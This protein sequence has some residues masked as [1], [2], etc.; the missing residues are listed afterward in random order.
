MTAPEPPKVAAGATRTTGRPAVLLVDDIPANLVALEAFLGRLDCEI[1]RAP[2][3]NE[4]LKQLLRREYAVV[5]LDVQMP[6][7]DGYE[8]A[9][10]IRQHPSTREIPII[11]VTAMSEARANLLRGYESGAVDFLFKPIDPVVLVSKVEVFLSLFRARQRLQDEIDAHRRTLAE[12]EAFNYSV[13]HDLRSPVRHVEAYSSILLE[14]HGAQ[15]DGEA[16][17]HLEKIHASAKKMA[18]H[19]E[20]L[21]SLSRARRSALQRT[22]FDLATMAAGIVGELRQ[23]EPRREVELV[24]P[25]ALPVTASEGLVRIALENL[26]R[27]AWKFTRERPSARIEVGVARTGDEPAYF[28]RD[29]G[30]GFDAAR[31]TKLFQPF[32]RFHDESRFEGSGLGLVIVKTIVERHGGELRVESAPEEGA[33]FTFTLPAAGEV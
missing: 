29:D 7:M 20:G 15:L 1:Y 2:S 19:M 17:A 9:G 23:A 3:G 21:V 25:Q 27:N 16:R 5:L 12:L 6:D 10:Y 4:A 8:V 22:T 24:L 33:T 13:S 18:S 14:D 28:V 30:A 31:A 11:F 32:R 26:L